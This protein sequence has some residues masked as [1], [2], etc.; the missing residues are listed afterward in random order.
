VLFVIASVF[1]PEKFQALLKVLTAQFLEASSPVP[2]MQ[3]Y[4]S[5]FTTGKAGSFVD[6]EYDSR[7][8]LVSQVKKVFETF[9]LEAV[10]IWVA[11]LCKK[12]IFVYSDKLAELQVFIRTFPAMGAWHRQ[13]FD[14]LRPFVTLSEV[15][16][17]DLSGAGVYV[18]GFTD[19]D[20]QN[21]R[22][23]Y[24]LFLNLQS[25]SFV[26]PDHAKDSFILTKFHKTTAEGF[27]K[28]CESSTDQQVIKEIALKTKELLDNTA[29]LRSEHPDGLYITLEELQQ[30]KLP[31]NADKFLYGVALA[32]GFCKK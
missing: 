12:R 14:L 11:M 17:K 21:K 13:N 27:L 2:I 16:L 10:V 28:V 3:S 24:D 29:S 8:A 31:P 23:F 4:L 30:K 25:K 1:N 15:E 7:R 19:P 20:A 9:G 6:A 32:E 22:E 18:A 26:I 5:V